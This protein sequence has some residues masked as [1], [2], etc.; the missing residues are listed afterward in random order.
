VLFRSF[1]IWP[2][3]LCQ[4][5]APPVLYRSKAWR[6]GGVAAATTRYRTGTVQYSGDT[7]RYGTVRYCT[8]NI[9][10]A[11]ASRRSTR[12]VR[13]FSGQILL[14]TIE[15]SFRRVRVMHLN[16][17]LRRRRWPPLLNARKRS[18]LAREGEVEGEV[19]MTSWQ[20]RNAQGRIR[21]RKH[22]P[23]L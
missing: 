8:K 20:A 18:R 12:S 14:N 9:I 3:D 13:L 17:P 15:W 22:L 19:L 16:L 10:T 2:R 5:Q 11:E 6:S 7:V 1:D 4:P 23:S 21:S